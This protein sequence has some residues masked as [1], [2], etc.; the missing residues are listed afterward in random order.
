MT[1]AVET[2]RPARGH[3]PSAVRMDAEILARLRKATG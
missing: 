3:T 1:V 2:R